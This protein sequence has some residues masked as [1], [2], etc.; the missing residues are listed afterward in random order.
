MRDHRK[1]LGTAGEDA[2]V[3]HLCR[4]G[5]RILKRNFKL[6]FGEIDIVAARDGCVCFVEVKTRENDFYS[7]P[8]EAV[9]EKKQNTIR[10]MAECFLEF[11][12]LEDVDVRFDVV[13]VIGRGPSDFVIEHLEDAF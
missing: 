1:S 12:G 6:S 7:D 8:F 9:H 13:T 10:K 4:Q 2:A 3:E 5:Y 11:K